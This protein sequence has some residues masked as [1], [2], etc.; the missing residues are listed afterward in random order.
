LASASIP[1]N[2]SPPSEIQLLARHGDTS[3]IEQ[4]NLKKKN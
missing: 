4:K 3:E 2:C 1:V